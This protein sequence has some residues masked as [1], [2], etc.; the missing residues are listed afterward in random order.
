MP[1]KTISSFLNQAQ[2]TCLEFYASG[3]HAFLLETTKTVQFKEAL[4]K[5]GDGLLK[6]LMV[7]LS[8]SEDCRDNETAI[9]RIERAI[10][11]LA[12]MKDCLESLDDKE[13]Q[14]QKD[15]QK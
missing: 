11:E 8:T 5:C 4:S 3:D 2:A 7:E 15:V 13:D 10:D 14:A 6:F 12:F 9:A 1:A